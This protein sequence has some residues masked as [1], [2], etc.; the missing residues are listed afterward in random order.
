MARKTIFLDSDTLLRLNA[1]KVSLDAKNN[2]EAIDQL[3]SMFD[4]MYDF[5]SVYNNAEYDSAFKQFF[6]EIIKKE[7][8]L[9]SNL[10]LVASE[11]GTVAING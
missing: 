1:V 5:Y 6:S 8:K 9:V 10:E 3:V 7:K 4:I 2:R 11:K